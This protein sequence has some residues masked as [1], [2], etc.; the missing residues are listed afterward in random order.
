MEHVSMNNIINFNFKS[1]LSNESRTKI[2]LI[3]F[4]RLRSVDFFEL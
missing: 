2:F 4:F 1:L 3:R